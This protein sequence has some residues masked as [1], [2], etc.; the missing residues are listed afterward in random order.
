MQS[1]Q[2][3][4]I[5]ADMTS[6]TSLSLSIYNLLLNVGDIRL[7]LNVG[8]IRLGKATNNKSKNTRQPPPP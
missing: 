7:L 3:C 5:A 2:L 1:D 8:D 4:Y 6:A